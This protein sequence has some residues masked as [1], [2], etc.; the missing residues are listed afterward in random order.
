MIGTINPLVLGFFLHFFSLLLHRGC[1]VGRNSGSVGSSSSGGITRSGSGITRGGSGIT[2][3]SGGV[4]DGT[5]S[6]VGGSSSCVRHSSGSVSGGIRGGC[7][8]VGRGSGSIGGS[9]S[10]L[11]GSLRRVGSSGVNG[12]L[13][14]TTAGSQSGGEGGNQCE[15]VQLHGL[16]SKED[17]EVTTFSRHRTGLS[18][19]REEIQGRSGI[20][21]EFDGNRGSFTATDAQ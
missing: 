16:F 4:G 18:C 19:G 17:V 11:F 15:L 9:I 21:H 2:R 3:S 20:L 10:S 12:L 7:G 1:S 8:S 6:G 13:G 5:R 14:V